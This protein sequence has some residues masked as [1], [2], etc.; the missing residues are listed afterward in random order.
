MP[1][2]RGMK[3]F[4]WLQLKRWLAVYLWLRLTLAAQPRY[5]EGGESSGGLLVAP[6]DSNAFAVALGRLID[7]PMLRRELGKRA[8]FRVEQKFSLPAVGAQLSA[9]LQRC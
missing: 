6:D 5:F 9:F 8:R 2:L 7:D 4:Q 1:S 3:D